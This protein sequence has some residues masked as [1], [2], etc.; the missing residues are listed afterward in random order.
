MK[1]N[2]IAPSFNA[3]YVSTVASILT[4]SPGGASGNV[5]TPVG[6]EDYDAPS[7]DDED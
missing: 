6:N 3:K 5:N 7:L 2:Y 1:K 4:V